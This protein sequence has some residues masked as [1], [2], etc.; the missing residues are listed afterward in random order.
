MRRHNS[1]SDE[2]TWDLKKYL[3]V[4][5]DK[6]YQNKVINNL[7]CSSWNLRNF[8]AS[9]VFTMQFSFTEKIKNMGKLIILE[10]RPRGGKFKN[11]STQ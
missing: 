8:A 9:I 1:K 11:N 4:I 7:K 3:G 2:V 6:C 10:K 5:N